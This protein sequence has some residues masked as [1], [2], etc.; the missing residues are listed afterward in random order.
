[1][2]GYILEKKRNAETT[3]SPPVVL[4]RP[5]HL[6]EELRALVVNTLPV[7]KKRIIAYAHSLSVT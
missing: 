7:D 1:M 4:H 3:L 2:L 5:V 6:A